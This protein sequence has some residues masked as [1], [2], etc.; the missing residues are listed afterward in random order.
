MNDTKKESSISR[1]II[2]AVIAP[3]SVSVLYLLSSYIGG[4]LQI[5]VKD[6]PI[7]KYEKVAEIWEVTLLNNSKT[8]AVSK[9]IKCD[10]TMDS[11]L[12]QSAFSW[13]LKETIATRHK[14]APGNNRSIRI[15]LPEVGFL[16]EKKLHLRVVGDDESKPICMFVNSLNYH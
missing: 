15:S 13:D 8:R 12:Y 16:E 11:E 6:R 4:G 14:R 5:S 2:I 1:R 7:G 3:I 9:Y 10:C